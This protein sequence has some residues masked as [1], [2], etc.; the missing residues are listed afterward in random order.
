MDQPAGVAEGAAWLT[1]YAIE[2]GKLAL[3]HEWFAKAEAAAAKARD[4][5]TDKWINEVKARL[6]EALRSGDSQ[7]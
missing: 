7:D 5:G 3:A 1:I 6:N 4:E 2:N